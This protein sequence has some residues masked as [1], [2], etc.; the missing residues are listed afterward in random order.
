MSNRNELK[1]FRGLRRWLSEE[2]GRAIAT[3]TDAL[4]NRIAQ[5]AERVLGLVERAAALEVQL[6]E[7]LA[8]I[9]D[10]LGELVRLQ[11]EE[12]RSRRGPETHED[13]PIQRSQ[14]IIDVE[15][16]S[17]PTPPKR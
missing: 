8:P 6:L 7:R 2:A 1:P 14:T 9:V 11:L 13:A 3:P 5:R 16:V 15:F 4:R 10:N 17:S 12:A